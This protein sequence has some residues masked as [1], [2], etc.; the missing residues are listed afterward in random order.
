VA[1]AVSWTLPRIE[2]KAVAVAVPSLFSTMLAFQNWASP[3]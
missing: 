1:A 3:F 2:A